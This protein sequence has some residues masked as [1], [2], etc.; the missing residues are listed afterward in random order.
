MREGSGVLSVG[1][2][3]LV[4]VGT[5]GLLANEFVFDW[6]R[7]ATLIFAASNAIGLVGV[8]FALYGGWKAKSSE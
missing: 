6:G 3:A 8:G 2:F 1:A 5:L 7:G 4:I